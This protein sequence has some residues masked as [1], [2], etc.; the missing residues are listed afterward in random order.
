[1]D[2]SESTY[3]EWKNFLLK[4]NLNDIVL[5]M[6]VWNF[7]K[8]YFFSNTYVG[9]DEHAVK[10][11]KKMILFA[12]KRGFVFSSIE[13][14]VN[15]ENNNYFDEE[16]DLC[17]GINGKFLMLFNNFARF[18]QIGRLNKKYF[19][20]YTLFYLFVLCMILFI[21]KLLIF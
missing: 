10:K 20:F 19:I 5:T 9:A 12:K 16:V 13:E 21:L 7:I 17:E 1:M 14:G 11:F 8:K 2:T 18:Q 15:K 4:T 6:H 3:N